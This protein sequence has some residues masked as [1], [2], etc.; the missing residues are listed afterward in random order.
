MNSRTYLGL[1]GLDP[2]YKDFLVGLIVWIHYHQGRYV[3]SGEN[4]VDFGKSSPRFGMID[5]G[6]MVWCL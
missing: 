5:C 4:G 1:M 3:V 6:I 2:F